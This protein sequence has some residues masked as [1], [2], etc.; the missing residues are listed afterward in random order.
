[1]EILTINK[2][3][4]KDKKTVTFNIVKTPSD[5]AVKLFKTV[6]LGDLSVSFNEELL[7]ITSKKYPVN[8]KDVEYV[9]KTM[10]KSEIKADQEEKEEKATREA[11]LKDIATATKIPLA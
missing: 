9:L 8:D 3:E 10:N 11:M 7:A 1:M 4:T 2:E 5:R 6:N